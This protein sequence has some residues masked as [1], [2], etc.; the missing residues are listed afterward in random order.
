[1]AEARIVALINGSLAADSRGLTRTVEEVS[2]KA[3][4]GSPFRPLVARYQG[5]DVEL[6]MAVDVS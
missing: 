5:L 4:E 2:R 1:M 3:R 6:P